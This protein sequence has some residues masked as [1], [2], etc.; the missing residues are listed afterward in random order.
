MGAVLLL[1]LH[2]LVAR[3][4]S[5]D[6]EYERVGMGKVHENCL[7]GE[8][9]DV[10]VVWTYRVQKTTREMVRIDQGVQLYSGSTSIYRL[11]LSLGFVCHLSYSN[12]RKTN[13]E[14]CDTRYPIGCKKRGL[15]PVGSAS[16]RAG[17]QVTFCAAKKPAHAHVAPLWM[18][19]ESSR[20]A[21]Q[22]WGHPEHATV[23]TAAYCMPRA[24]RAPY[25]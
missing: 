7:V 5:V 22:L 16:G 21:P 15:N 4:T 10:R 6:G 20:L 19:L 2:I 23:C 25:P 3:P 8:R 13:S 12:A 14:G 11:S 18:L 24:A 17:Q 1:L 9:V